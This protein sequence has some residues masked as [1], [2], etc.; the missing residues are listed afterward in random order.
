[1][2]VIVLVLKSIFQM[3]SVDEGDE[4]RQKPAA[5]PVNTTVDGTDDSETKTSTTSSK[6]SSKKQPSTKKENTKEK[7]GKKSKKQM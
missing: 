6:K 3:A 2:H 1:M 7:K 4:V 5:V